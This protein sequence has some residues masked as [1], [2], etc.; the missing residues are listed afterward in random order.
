MRR[1]NKEREWKEDEIDGEYQPVPLLVSI[2]YSIN[3]PRVD[4]EAELEG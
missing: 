4:D 2:E 1:C 3:K